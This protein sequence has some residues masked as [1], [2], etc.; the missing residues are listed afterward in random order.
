[1]TQEPPLT[2]HQLEENLSSELEDDKNEILSS[3][4]SHDRITEIVDGCIPI[5]HSEL[6][7]MASNNTEMATNEPE[8]MAFDGHNT[9]I[10]AIAGNI[11]QHLQEK[12]Y[13]WLDDA[14]KELAK[15]SNDKMVDE[16][17][18]DELNNDK[19]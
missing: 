6:L 18:E 5:Y 15:N 3:E 8:I 9:P 7:E 16:M 19:F 17:I 4:Y 14:Q 2:L 13:K 1:M 10:N 12:A 11:Y